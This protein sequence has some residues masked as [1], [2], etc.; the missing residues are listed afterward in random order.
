MND[1]CKEIFRGLHEGKW[2]S[3]QYHNK[4]DAITSY[5]IGIKDFDPI[6]GI[7]DVC[8]LHLGFLKSQNFRIRIEGIVA[9][10]LVEGTY[11]E[12]NQRL[13][14]D[15]SIHP[16]KYQKYFSNSAN[17]RILDYLAECNRLDSTPYQCDY[18]LLQ[19]FDE[20]CLMEPVYQLSQEQFKSI[21]AHFQIK[22]TEEA[23]HTRIKQL[24]MNVIS[25]PTSM[26]LYVLAY[27]R[28]DLNVEHRQLK[29]AKTITVCKNFTL[30]GEQVSAYQFLDA[31]DYQLLDH[32]EENLEY[33]KDRITQY[34]PHIQG[35]DDMPYLMAVGCD[36][37][38]NLHYEYK[39][40]TEMY[41]TEDG[42]TVPIQAFFGDLIRTPIR[43]KNYPLAL[44]NQNANLDQFLAIHN[45]MKYPLTYVQGPPG[46]GK[47]S[48][49]VNTLSTAFFNGRTVLFTSYNNHPIDGV[50]EK[51]SHLTYRGKVIPFPIIRLG[52]NWKVADAIEQIRTL[53]KNSRSIQ[54]FES[55][56]ERKKDTK[57]ERTQQ[58]TELL[59]QHEKIID[60]KNRKEALEQMIQECAQNRMDI[61]VELMAQLDRV[62][63]ELRSCGEITTEDAKALLKDDKEE[64]LKYLYYTSAKFIQRIDEP[65]NQDLLDILNQTDKD[66]R[67]VAFNR[68]LSTEENLKKFLRIFPI[69]ATTC[70]SAQKVGPP[71]PIFDM[72]I[73]DEASQCNNAVS[74]VPIVRGKNLMLVGDP[75]QLSPV[76]LLDEA[77]NAS[78]REKYGVSAEYDYL[79]NSIYKTML[80]CDSVS[81]EILL[82]NH[83]RCHKSIIEFNN[84][85]YYNRK[86]NILSNVE[87]EKPLVYVD[88]PSVSGEKKNTAPAEAEQIIQFALQNPD[89]KIGVITPFV[90]QK[91]YINDLMQAA[92]I[93]NI[94][95]GTVHAFQGDEKDVILFSLALTE[96]TSGKTYYW[97]RNN[98]ELINVAT[99]RACEQLIVLSNGQV[100][101]K[102][103][104]ASGA[105]TDDIYELVQ[106]VR[107]NGETEIT[108]RETNSR[109][110]GIK[111]YSTET[112][113][114]FWSSLNH[115]LDNID[116]S[117]HRYAVH[118]EV[119]ISQV[120]ETNITESALFYTGRF[121]F[122]LYE[123]H[124]RGSQTPVFAIELDGKEHFTDAVVK[125]RDAEKAKICEAHHFQLI[126]IENTYARRYHYIKSILLKYFARK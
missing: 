126:R 51:L 115:A 29:A 48:T 6:T 41:Q 44:I 46:T 75:Q 43:R 121:D 1:I 53:Y 73:M 27:R 94:T 4:S 23:S 45:A 76:I 96:K 61:R 82:H 55:S 34:N 118:K 25:I 86:L 18:R 102:L 59:E 14:E 12:V 81:D 57:I 26:G 56:L 52:N 54:I 72:V 38:V 17:L 30:N 47:T 35:V 124:F 62:E 36:T 110:L 79:K 78:L 74:L 9:A 100:L 7:L 104:A 105:D 85:K 71:K 5:W 99:S 122:V 114:A 32:I 111:P 117:L 15:I 58:L 93:P 60:L 63:Q 16:E 92:K 31:D 42:I 20:D 70:I 112:E 69:V 49:I 66:A 107:S 3:I 116:F 97:L 65:K 80:A 87:S 101:N 39:G 22:S 84:R 19:H 98:K 64:F 120:F 83:Y 68:Y 28:L 11:C 103:H 77:D 33:I 125:K 50:V 67:V 37:L 13:I 2:V 40:I 95:S 10:S 106:Y 24:C 91:N 90:N 108:P 8:G 123:K 21:V 113:T 89:K 109:A 119:A 88:V